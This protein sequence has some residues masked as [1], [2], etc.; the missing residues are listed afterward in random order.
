MGLRTLRSYQLDG[1]GD[2]DDDLDVDRADYYFVHDCLTKDG[3]GILGAGEKPARI[4]C[5]RAGEAIQG[6]VRASR[7]KR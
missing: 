7:K 2:W 3:P 1:S 4:L 5:L 6:P